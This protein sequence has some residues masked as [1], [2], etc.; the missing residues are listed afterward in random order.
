M[1][2]TLDANQIQKIDRPYVQPI[3]LVHLLLGGLTLYF[4]DRCLPYNGH[5]YEDYLFDLSNIGNEIRN[6]GGMDNAQVTLRFKNDKILAKNT[7]IELFDDYPPEKKYVEIYKLYVD[8]LSTNLGPNLVTNGGMEA[9]NPPTG[10]APW[11]TPETFERSTV[12]KYGGSYSCHVIDSTASYGGFYGYPVNI[13]VITGR[14][15]K[16]SFRYYIESGVLNPTFY[17]GST[18]DQ[19]HTYSATGSWL[20]GEIYFT[21]TNTGDGCLIFANNSN[22][23]PAEFYID[24][25]SIQE[26]LD[27]SSYYQETFAT[28]VSTKIFKGEMG[29][30]EE[31][32]DPPTDFKINCSLMLFGKNASLPLDVIDLADFPSADPDDVGKYR[33]IVYGPAK[34]IVCPWT[35]AG[36]LSTLTADITA[37]ATSIVVTDSNGAPATPFSAFID[38]E[39]VSV[40][41]NTKATG[42]LTITRAQGGTTAVIH[43]KGAA[44]YEKRTDFEAEVAQH[45]VKAI[46]DVFVKRGSG[47]WLRV[48]SGVTKNISTGG[49]ATLVFS[50]KVKYE[51]KTNVTPST[52]TGTHPHTASTSAPG[53]MMKKCIPTSGGNAADGNEESYTPA[54]GA[55]CG[56]TETNLGTVVGQYV[57]IK[58]AVASSTIQVTCGGTGL[59]TTAAVTGWQRKYKSGGAWGD[60]VVCDSGSIAEIYKEVI[61][62][63]SMTTTVNT[64]AADGVSTTMAGNSVANMMI[65]DL[66][67]CDVD[68]YQD[69]AGGTYTGTGNAL[70]ERPD[71]VRKHILIALLGFAAGDIGASFATVGTV[72]GTQIAGG[73]KFAF[74]LP[75]V[76]TETMDLFQKMDLQ[77]RSN[78]FESGGQFCLAFGST[79]DPTSQI[80]FGEADGYA[81]IKGRIK[82]GKTEVADIK[83]TLVGHY[84]RDYS[85]SGGRGDRYQKVDSAHVDSASVTKYKTQREEIEF[86]CIGDLATMVD[87]VL[88]WILIEKKELKKTVEI[89]AYWDAMI[90]EHCD[91]FTVVSSFWSGLKYKTV[92]LLERPEDQIIELKGLQFVSS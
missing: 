64:H 66:V 25:I 81:R 55:N 92:K 12:R 14:I 41:G 38:N 4:S 51:Q 34:R 72:Y 59:G 33:N 61:Y 5:E 29:Q 60:N 44:I 45:P 78:M 57:W 18:Y 91:Y 70:I 1:V 67:A 69:D 77:S 6:L 31:I 2:K 80:T 84:F 90:M 63:P 8:T 23:V 73:Y 58:L 24:D 27:T 30:P 39:E 46:G 21:S 20:L 47:E 3:Y 65:G 82:F 86:S 88:D 15:Y 48:I 75:E 37:A 43:N 42:T 50:D 11:G 9:G 54:N 52:D 19:T 56:F 83:N 35:V 28:D 17:D 71:H 85:K 10:W 68:G 26:V 13:P 36:W 53:D 22:T 49:R 76:A 74:N 16:V 32:Y 40:T 89:E 87:D 7:L 79:S 62:T